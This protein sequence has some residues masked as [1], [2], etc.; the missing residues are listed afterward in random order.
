LGP[1]DI[2]PSLLTSTRFARRSCAATALART[3]RS[4]LA[5]G[6]RDEA[7]ARAGLGWIKDRL[8]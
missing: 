7:C 5:R 8:M 2:T 1:T 4:A 6:D 3:R